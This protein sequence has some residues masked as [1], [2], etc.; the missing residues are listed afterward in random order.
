MPCVKSRPLNCICRGPEPYA[1]RVDSS[2]RLAAGP[3]NRARNPFPERGDVV[4][5]SRLA[6]IG[7]PLRVGVAQHLGNL[8]LGTGHRPAGRHH[9]RPLASARSTVCHHSHPDS[10]AR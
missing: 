7:A 4:T 8:L 3:V 6:D 5:R 10:T 2:E 1:V 9:L